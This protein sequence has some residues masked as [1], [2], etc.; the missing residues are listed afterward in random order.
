M[1]WLKVDSS[2]RVEE[3]EGAGVVE[4]EGE[5]EEEEE[6]ED[7]EDDDEEDEDEEEEE[8]E[9]CDEGEKWKTKV[10]KETTVIQ[11]MCSSLD[12]GFRSPSPCPLGWLQDSSCLAS[13]CTRR[14]EVLFLVGPGRVHRSSTSCVMGW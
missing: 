10:K 4:K 6:E 9:E 3:A 11:G 13:G 8:E 12:T 2:T 7:D 5:S 1:R 14:E